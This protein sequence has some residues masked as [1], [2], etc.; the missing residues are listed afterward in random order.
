[1]RRTGY[2]FYLNMSVLPLPPRSRYELVIGTP[3]YLHLKRYVVRLR[4]FIGEI[5]VIAG[6]MMCLP[7]AGQMLDTQVFKRYAALA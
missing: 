2:G 7:V 6:S 1:M 5:G 4:C 3:F